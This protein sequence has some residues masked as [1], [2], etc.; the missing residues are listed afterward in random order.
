M[1]YLTLALCVPVLAMSSNDV[2]QACVRHTQDYNQAAAC[3]AKWDAQQR[4]AKLNELRQQLEDKDNGRQDNS[5]SIRRQHL[6]T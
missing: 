6:G 1:R 5:R 3:F 4:A 2:L